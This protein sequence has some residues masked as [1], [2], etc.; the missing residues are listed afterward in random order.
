[1]STSRDGV[2][3]MLLLRASRLLTM[4]PITNVRSA[5][6]DMTPAKQINGDLTKSAKNKL[7]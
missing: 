1:M 5:D 4:T 2:S 7:S 3:S 6:V